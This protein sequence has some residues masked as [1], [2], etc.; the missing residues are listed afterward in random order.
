[1]DFQ[2]LVM[3][4][5]R[6]LRPT[7]PTGTPVKLA[8]LIQ[9]CWDPIPSNRLD[10]NT[11][12][13]ALK[14]LQ[15]DYES[16][17]KKWDKLIVKYAFHRAGQGDGSASTDDHDHNV[18]LSQSTMASSSTSTMKT[19]RPLTSHLRTRR[20]SVWR[21][22]HLRDRPGRPSNGSPVPALN[23]AGARR[24]SAP[25]LM[26]KGDA[27]ASTSTGR[28][29]PSKSPRPKRVGSVQASVP[30]Q[31]SGSDTNDSPRS[32]SGSSSPRTPPPS[33][34]SQ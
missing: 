28:N 7:I 1:M 31:R 10:A 3:A 30:R 5:K 13:E 33:S 34:P 20:D 9:A 2:T 24:D 32:G 21:N 4:R 29:S 12:V 16:K 17:P 14:E 27:A 26:E 18:T 8:D 15:E 22:I 23:T 19:S 11:V 6:S 25:P